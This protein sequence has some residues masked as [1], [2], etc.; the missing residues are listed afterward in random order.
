MI[1]SAWAARYFPLLLLL[2]VQRLTA[3]EFTMQGG[4]SPSGRYAVLLVHDATPPA[5]SDSN[6]AD[7]KVVF[8]D[9]RTRK[10][11]SLKTGPQGFC[12]FK[13]AQDP[14]NSQAW[15]SPDNRFVAFCFRTTRHSREPY[16]YRVGDGF[17]RRVV[18][19]DY[20]AVIYGRLGVKPFNGHYVRCPTKWIDVHTLE[21]FSWGDMNE[22][23]ITLKIQRKRNH[24]PTGSI[25]KV[26]K[27]EPLEG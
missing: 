7:Y 23:H 25:T 20:G 16:L 9:L 21:L 1:Q 6:Q 8:R 11:Q 26:T 13:G 18:L 17:I 2:F 15:W 3:E 4:T 27:G 22:C 12:N 19:P 10:D 14:V 5:D 24:P